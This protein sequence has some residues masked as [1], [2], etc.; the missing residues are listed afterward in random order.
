RAAI[1]PDRQFASVLCE[2]SCSFS[3]HVSEMRR[4]VSQRVRP[5]QS[6]GASLSRLFLCQTRSSLANTLTKAGSKLINVGS[7]GLCLDQNV[8]PGEVHKPFAAPVL[9]CQ[10]RREVRS[11]TF[12]S[13]TGVTSYSS[14]SF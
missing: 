4:A 7:V 14:A 5:A 12:W 8:W 6:P 1:A 3:P 2:K 9:Y 13:E 11:V 10:A